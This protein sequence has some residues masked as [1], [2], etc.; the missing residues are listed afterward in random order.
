MRK[1]TNKKKTNNSSL[2]LVLLIMFF[3]ILIILGGLYGTWAYFTDTSSAKTT[4]LTFGTL[5]SLVSVNGGEFAQSQNLSLN[6]YTDS[7][8]LVS[9]ASFKL[10]ENSVNGYMR[11]A[12]GYMKEQSVAQS[13]VQMLEEVCTAFNSE[14][15]SYVTHSTSSYKWVYENGYFYLVSAITMLP[16]EIL[17]GNEYTLF[18]ETSS[19]ALAL[20]DIM[21]FGLGE[22]ASVKGVCLS[23]EAQVVQSANIGLISS[24][25][26]FDT[27]LSNANIFT[28]P[29]VEYSKIVLF[30]TLGA[31][32]VESAFFTGENGSVTLPYVGTG[33][34]VTWY[35]GYNAGEFSHEVG[36]SGTSV[37]FSESTIL[38]AKYDAS[39][40]MVYFERGEGE[41][42]L[43][44]SKLITAND[45]IIV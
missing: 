31:P 24:I 37:D 16:I 3:G 41:G 20:P 10:K 39:G 18:S 4:S 38:Y 8:I 43:P 23:I 30:N 28:H 25:T 1:I 35:R 15:Y 42:E 45:N 29:I 12:I 21:R 2:K 44:A 32:I 19:T 5:D 27:L 14:V 11:V 36:K 40:V 17:A 33:T 9:S 22:G 26:S 34:S 6:N 7:N 13:S